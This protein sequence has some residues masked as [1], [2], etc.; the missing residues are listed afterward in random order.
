MIESRYHFSRHIIQYIFVLGETYLLSDI[1]H[2][3]TLKERFDKNPFRKDD[4][5]RLRKGGVCMC[6]KE[7]LLIK[8]CVHLETLCAEG[9]VTEITLHLICGRLSTTWYVIIQF[10]SIYA[11]FR[12]TSGLY[13]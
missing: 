3:E 9:T 12:I 8:R 7:N 4:P 1:S 5:S 6:F 11:M 13:A 2:S 10:C